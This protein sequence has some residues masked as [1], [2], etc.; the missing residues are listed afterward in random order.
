MRTGSFWF[1][2]IVRGIHLSYNKLRTVQAVALPLPKTLAEA[3]EKAKAIAIVVA[4][5]VAMAVKQQ[6]QL[7]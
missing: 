5:A 7:K 6:W 2:V 4:V 3:E 1:S